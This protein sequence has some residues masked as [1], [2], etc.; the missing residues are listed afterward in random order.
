[1]SCCF[2]LF[3]KFELFT[4]FFRLGFLFVCGLFEISAEFMRKSRFFLR[5]PE[6]VIKAKRILVFLGVVCRENREFNSK[7]HD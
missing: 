6:R 7:L 5:K 2:F 1:M 3:F 4:F